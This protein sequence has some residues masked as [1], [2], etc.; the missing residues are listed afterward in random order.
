M[1]LN[2][3]MRLKIKVSIRKRKREREMNNRSKKKRN[4]KGFSLVELIVVIAVMAVLVGVLAPAYLRYVDKSRLQKDISAIAEVQRAIQVCAA[5]PDV[6]EEIALP[7]DVSKMFENQGYSGMTHAKVVIKSGTGE[8]SAKRLD[9]Q[10]RFNDSEWWEIMMDIG[11]VIYNSSFNSLYEEAPVLQEEVTKTVGESISF[12]TE[13]LSKLDI[14][15]TVTRDE[16]YNV[17]VTVNSDAFQN[18]PDIQEELA[19]L[20]STASGA[21][22]KEDNAW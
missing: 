11:T 20:G 12:E 7:G 10:Q 9:L 2:A 1:Y 13:E 14:I 4:K 8:I 3:E 17:W 22:T 18:Y 16:N 6:A 15:F 5:D 21:T 19:T